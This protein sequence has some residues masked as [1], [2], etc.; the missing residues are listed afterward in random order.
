MIVI[1]IIG[2]LVGMLTPTISASY[3]KA[4]ATNSKTFMSNMCAALER[5]KDDNGD[6]P[7]FLS[8]SARVN[9]D[10]AT[11]RKNSTKHSLER[12]PTAADC[13]RPTGAS[14]TAARRRIWISI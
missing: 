14:L 6:F 7:A 8:S 13:L 4:L 10:D 11:T 12:I 9:L 1:A 5:Y 3:K 2:V